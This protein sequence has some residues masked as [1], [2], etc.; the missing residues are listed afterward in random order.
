MSGLQSSTPIPALLGQY[1][2]NLDPALLELTATGPPP[3]R[4]V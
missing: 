1:G 3:T 2:A 4:S